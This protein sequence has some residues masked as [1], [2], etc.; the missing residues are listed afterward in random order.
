MG[1]RAFLVEKA[2]LRLS[3]GGP[4]A[5]AQLEGADREEL[6]SFKAEFEIQFRCAH[7]KRWRMLCPV[8]SLARC[9]DTSTHAVAEIRREQARGN[10]ISRVAFFRDLPRGATLK[11]VQRHSLV[12]DIVGYTYT[13]GKR[14]VIDYPV[15]PRGTVDLVHIIS[16]DVESLG[17]GGGARDGIA[18][19]LKVDV[20][21]VLVELSRI[22]QSKMDFGP[23]WAPTPAGLR[24]A[25]NYWIFGRDGARESFREQIR[26]VG[27]TK[28]RRIIDPFGITRGRSLFRR[29]LRNFGR[30][31]RRRCRRGPDSFV[32]RPHGVPPDPPDRCP[33]RRHSRGDPQRA[34]VPAPERRPQA[35]AG[36]A[37]GPRLLRV[38]QARR[39]RALQ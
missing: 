16:A 30:L 9:P 4:F 10:A 22:A 1:A 3:F 28:S 36:P 18:A 26:E 34:E 32:R 7:S 33:T 29:R 23:N 35:R 20:G 11:L 37:G 14:S 6:E 25:R 24:R 21:E 5:D 13:R 8:F 31:L 38:L 17:D 39:V 15:A 12:P 19:Q 2:K 27:A